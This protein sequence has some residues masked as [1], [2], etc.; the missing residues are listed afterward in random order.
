[1]GALVVPFAQIGSG[2]VL[3]AGGKGA[4]LGEMTRA[5][6]PVPPGAVV[7]TEAFRMA[8]ASIDPEGS[9]QRRVAALDGDD[10]AAVAAVSSTAIAA[11]ESRALPD[12]LVDDIARAY[13]DLCRGAGDDAVP[14]AVRSSATSEDSAE[15]SFA[16]QQDTYLWVRGV[17]AVTEAVRS[18]WASLYSVDS[19][20]YRRRRDLPEDGLAMAVVIQRMV[21]ARSSGVAFT[22]SPRTGDRSVVAV[23]AAWGL[24]SA[25]VGGE[26][27]PDSFVLSKVTGEIISR[28]IARKTTRD[29]PA[30]DG[31]GIATVPV[32]EA[33]QERP[34]VTDD[35]LAELGRIAD[36]VESHYG[37][38][39]DIEWAIDHEGGELFL[40]Q[41]RPETVWASKDTEAVPVATPKKH[42]FDHVVSL[43]SGT[44]PTARK[45]R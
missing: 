45:G 6:I 26:V 24:G 5:G 10:F 41:S 37:R 27:T 38:P 12:E 23:D 34:A 42:A 43:M 31:A 18:C 22:R 13:A 7:T 44:I 21:H 2:D 11:V 30:A 40:L 33:D 16:G 8:M 1:M 32:P 28:T 39:Q 25:V 14:V 17:Q 9:L 35:E 36:A 3:I 19:I 4:S 15:A 29:E 20:T